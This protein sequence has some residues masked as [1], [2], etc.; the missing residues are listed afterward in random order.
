MPIPDYQSIMLPLLKFAADGKDHPFREAVDNL[1]RTFHLSDSELKELLPSGKQPIF[2]NRVGWATTY[3]KKAGL[4]AAPKRGSMQIT[5][6]GLGLLQSN[7]PKV[8]VKLLSQY[9]EF[10]EFQSLKQL[11][12]EA[13]VGKSA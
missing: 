4:L 11:L 9:P 2:A 7:P 5:E 13:S 8:N 12:G 1:S 3:M 6:R 10:V